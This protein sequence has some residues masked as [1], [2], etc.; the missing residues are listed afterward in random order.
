MGCNINDKKLLC[1]ECSEK[2][3]YQSKDIIIFKAKL[4]EKNNFILEK[5]EDI[6]GEQK[7]EKEKNENK[8]IC[9]GCLQNIEINQKNKFYYT[10]HIIDNNTGYPTNYD[11]LSATIVTPLSIF[12]DTISTICILNNRDDLDLVFDKIKSKYSIDFDTIFID[13]EYSII[14]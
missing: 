2:D 1:E 14:S 4:P 9:E 13:K 5:V 7:I 12:G 10:Y 11:L 6:F 3:E 8:L